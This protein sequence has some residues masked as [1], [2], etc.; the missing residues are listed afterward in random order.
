MVG[1]LR[2]SGLTPVRV[3]RGAFGQR[4]AVAALPTPDVPSDPAA[5]PDPLGAGE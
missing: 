1:L 3:V 2:R 4:Y 5:P